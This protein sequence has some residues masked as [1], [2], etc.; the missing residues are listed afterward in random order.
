MRDVSLAEYMLEV[1]TEYL[2]QK[3][4]VLVESRVALECLIRYRKGSVP[5]RLTARGTPLKKEAI[6]A[7]FTTISRRLRAESGGP[8]R[9]LAP[10]CIHQYD[11]TP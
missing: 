3:G 9:P 1:V 7:P 2:L 6:R 11:T 5:S 4:V 10:E 8:V